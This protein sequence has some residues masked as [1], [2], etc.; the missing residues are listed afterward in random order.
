MK[1]C[2]EN[3]LT[4]E[5]KTPPRLLSSFRTCNST[6][7]RMRIATAVDD[8]KKGDLVTMHDTVR[9]KFAATA[10]VAVL[11]WKDAY[12]ATPIVYWNLRDT[13]DLV[14]RWRE[15]HRWHRTSVRFQSLNAEASHKR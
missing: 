3:K 10:T 12:P 1:V 9:S 2:V 15:G 8:D 6:T 11:G 5:D 4:K 7:V 13:E 14:I